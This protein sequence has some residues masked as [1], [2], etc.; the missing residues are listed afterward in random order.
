MSLKSTCFAWTWYSVLG[1]TKSNPMTLHNSWINAWKKLCLSG[2]IIISQPGG[3][4][5]EIC[6]FYQPIKSQSRCNVQMKVWS[7][8]DLW[9]HDTVRLGCWSEIKAQESES[10]SGKESNKQIEL[11]VWI[12][13]YADPLLIYATKQTFIHLSLSL[14]QNIPL[15]LPLLCGGF[16]VRGRG[17]YSEHLT[18]GFVK[19]INK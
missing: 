17:R 15:Q 7:Q 13:M 19:E 2:I 16:S 9:H 10:S 11:N 14:S 1:R 6:S 8:F 18:R 5:R 12:W 3:Q 4:Y